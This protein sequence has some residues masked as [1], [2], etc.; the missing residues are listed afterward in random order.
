MSSPI[1]N[2]SNGSIANR[3]R[4]CRPLHAKESE[5]TEFTQKFHPRS[6]ILKYRFT[7]L[8][9]GTYTIPNHT[10]HRPLFLDVLHRSL[11]SSLPS[12][13]M[14]IECFA[15]C[16]CFP[17]IFPCLTGGEGSC[18]CAFLRPD[19]CVVHPCLPCITCLVWSHD[20][21]SSNRLSW[22]N[23][24][25]LPL[26]LELEESNDYDVEQKQQGQRQSKMD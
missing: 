7:T 6:N 17:C 19:C 1:T 11:S 21:Q 10:T 4:R 23:N 20:Q 14:P 15:N 16:F 26:D 12:A 9:T 5:K 3:R 13:T 18:C 25:Y 24:K 22:H 8:A 2:L